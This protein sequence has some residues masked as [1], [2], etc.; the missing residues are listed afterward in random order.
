[1]SPPALTNPPA[2]PLDDL[3]D[4]LSPYQ[5]KSLDLIAALETGRIEEFL[6]RL[7]KDGAFTVAP[8]DIAFPAP[9]TAVTVSGKFAGLA[10]GALDA[11]IAFTLATD[12]KTLEADLSLSEDARWGWSGAKWLTLS[13]PQIEIRLSEATATPVVGT[14][15]ASIGTGSP[16]ASMSIQ[17]PGPTP[18][19]WLFSGRFPPEA[20]LSQ[21][22]QL[23]G[24]VNLAAALPSF[25]GELSVREVAAVYSQAT[26][27]LDYVRVEFGTEAKWHPLPE[28]PSSKPPLALDSI[29]ISIT[30]YEPATTQSLAWTV[31]GTVEIGGGTVAVTVAYPDPRVSATLDTGT[32]IDLS[33][34][35]E[36]FVGHEIDL[37]A[38]VTS[39]EFDRQIEPP[40]A[41]LISAGIDTDWSIPVGG[42]AKL[43]IAN[44]AFEIAG[45]E[46]S[47]TAHL[48]GTIAIGEAN[49][50]ILV[51]AA[52]YED[53]KSGW[54]FSATETAGVIPLLE[55]ATG[56]LPSGWQPDPGDKLDVEDLAISA[57]PHTGAYSI[58]GKVDGAWSILGGFELE[59]TAA[60][61]Y[62]G[63]DYSGKLEAT[64]EEAFGVKRLG[65]H[66]SYSFDPKQRTYELDWRGLSGT[67]EAPT[68][69]TADSKLE[70]RVQSWTVGRLIEE[71]VSLAT[72]A[73]FS[74]ASPWDLLDDVDLDCTLTFTL[75][76]KDSGRKGTI[77]F[78]YP[79]SVNIGIAALSGIAVTYDEQTRAVNVQLDGRFPWQEEAK[80]LTWDATDP[81]TTPAP[82]GAG[83]KYLELRTLGLGQYI[84]LEEPPLTETVKEIV[85][86]VG[87]LSKPSSGTLPTESSKIHYS[88]A[89][90]WLIAA[91]FGIL[92]LDPP[93]KKGS[94]YFLDMALV[95][96]DPDLYGLHIELEG[97]PAKIFAGL[98][99]DV[100]YRKVTETVGVY[101]A[102]LQLPSGM[103]QFD[104]GA[105]SFTLPVFAIAVYTNGDFELDIGFPWNNDFSRSF[106]VQGVV[107]P[108]IPVIGA[109]GFYFG[110]LSSSTAGSNVP[111]TTKGAFNP[112]IVFGIGLQVGAGKTFQKGPLSA[113]L[114]ITV[115]AIVQGV[116]ARWHPSLPAGDDQPDEQ[117]Q[118]PYYFKLQGTAG[119]A[120]HMYG[121]VDFAVVKASVDVSLAISIQLTYESYRAIPIEVSASV[122]VDASLSIDLGLFTIHLH[123]SF[124]TTI[125]A[126]FTVGSSSVAPWDDG[127]ALEAPA[128]DLATRRMRML[129]IR[130]E[131]LYAI[132]A[133]EGVALTWSN[134][135]KAATPLSLTAYTTPAFTVVGDGASTPAQQT[136]ACVLL[137]WIQSVDPNAGPTAGADTSFEAL[138]KQVLRWAVAAAQPTPIS[139]ADVDD[140]VVSDDTL[141]K[142]LAALADPSD[143]LPIAPSDVDTFLQRN[144]VIQMSAPQQGS[145][146]ATYL[147]MPPQIELSVASL[148]IGPYSFEKFNSYDA[149]YVSYLQ[150]YFSE[151]EVQVQEEAP[152]PS[153]PSAAADDGPLSVASIVYAD[154]FAMVARQMV[155]AA[156]DALRDLK[157]PV[158]SGQSVEATVEAINEAGG[159]AELGPAHMYTV[160]Q[161]FEANATQPLTP[162]LSLGV[163]HVAERGDTLESIARPFAGQ[164][165]PTDLADSNQGLAGLL[166][167][168][169]AVDCSGHPP[170]TVKAQ[171]S[172]AGISTELGLSVAELIEKSN[173]LAAPLTPGTALL[174]PLAHRTEAGDS[175]GAIAASFGVSTS[176][177]GQP[178]AGNAALVNLFA[179]GD[180]PQ[181]QFLDVPHLPQYRLGDLIEEAQRSLAIQRLSGMLARYFLHGMRLPTETGGSEEA[182]LFALTGQQ[183]SLGKTPDI[184]PFD[185]ALSS[186]DEV[187]WLELA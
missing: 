138:A 23:V 147:P 161:L 22:F 120:V 108:G 118:G 144:A 42:T 152:K 53:E 10:L 68:D 106:T 84:A 115:L 94:A 105:F 98:Q 102:E 87:K 132:A 27:T 7:G 179:R 58:S 46:G 100:S 44:L 185:V 156:R 74:L 160:A 49:P 178:I 125:S 124:S 121:S 146:A 131:R 170:Y 55:L 36:R 159:L 126:T 133:G 75:P 78:T 184:A 155:D 112:V 168:G 97:A 89:S 107:P 173:L 28:L 61:A 137:V 119:L 19:T 71:L 47:S 187:A 140:L 95:F 29:A 114:T 183:L 16:P 33:E 35:V 38:E 6:S 76:P 182:G 171:D 64:L 25:L 52:A 90:S 17:V 153:P 45:Q 145:A 67:Y 41:Y 69:P 91:D 9:Y 117:L 13:G 175:L 73:R 134:L 81:S 34:F 59:A 80:P 40:E 31:A 24:G 37:K 4:K 26:E 30:V 56:Y 180:T 3:Y 166:L 157:L 96:N 83:S 130:S 15:G 122:E 32:T 60:V 8:A 63:K 123:F 99:L 154:Y 109:G 113:G 62:D 150:S 70:L 151:L 54:V 148:G 103:R 18:D 72:G 127:P 57:T 86:S 88:Q 142:I 143:P 50:V 177:L 139:S 92:K 65:L 77:S 174:L 164:T 11:K 1:M 149:S 136:A 181:E 5:G 43:E 172:L 116:V 85:D 93:P 141:E 20:N 48:S 104:V 14:L 111:A 169:T 2:G 158:P 165:S 51:L 129:A 12:A 110:K 39:F 162:G 135:E 186:P 21:V 128:A 66:V 163:A 82:P 101:Q 79:L 176:A 167:E